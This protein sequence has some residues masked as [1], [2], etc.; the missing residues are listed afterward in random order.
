M[1]QKIHKKKKRLTLHARN[2]HATSAAQNIIMRR[3]GAYL[4]PVVVAVIHQ[5]CWA[6]STT[7]TAV[8]VAVIKGQNVSVSNICTRHQHVC[9]PVHCCWHLYIHLKKYNDQQCKIWEFTTP[10]GCKKS[11][12]T[13]LKLDVL[14]LKLGIL[15]V[16]LGISE[17]QNRVFWDSNMVF[18]RL[19]LGISELKMHIAETWTWCF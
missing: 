18:L 8:L 1:I 17:T 4:H 11:Q 5:C 7:A 9:W 15:R 19:K 12:T 6:T 2:E 3:L 14:R 16:K 10:L 13:H